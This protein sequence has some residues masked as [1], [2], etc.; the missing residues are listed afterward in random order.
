MPIL[1][2]NPPQNGSTPVFGAENP[3]PVYVMGPA[4]VT[5]S[6]QAAP[7]DPTPQTPSI[8]L[9][10]GALIQLPGP[11]MPSSS[12]VVNETGLPSNGD[13]YVI[14]DPLGRINVGGRHLFIDGG[15]YPILG[16]AQL[17]LTVAYEGA[18]LEFDDT[19]QAWI[20]CLCNEPG[21]G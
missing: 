19:A 3:G 12:S 2:T 11:R 18:H 17:E 14:A 20:C 13:F 15:G 6:V 16:L 5:A 8:A 1:S 7:N 4:D 10:V 21:D 9:P